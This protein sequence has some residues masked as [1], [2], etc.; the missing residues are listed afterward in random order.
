MNY[1]IKVLAEYIA[2]EKHTGFDCP[3]AQ[4]LHEQLPSNCLG[5]L[6]SKLCV[7]PLMITLTLPNE[8]VWR[9]PAPREVRQFIVKYDANLNYIAPFS[10]NIDLPDTVVVDEL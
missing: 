1:T 2:L 8:Q 4:A 5:G 9:I 6:A 7:Q 10:F 3:V